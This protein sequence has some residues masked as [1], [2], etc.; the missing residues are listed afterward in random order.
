MID[1]NTSQLTWIVIGAC[2]LGGTGYLTV[3]SNMA[4]IDKKIEIT[5]TK[6]DNMSDKFTELQTQLIRIE[7]KIDKKK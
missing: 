7:D 2:S 1:F 4:N 6:M 5:N 3:N